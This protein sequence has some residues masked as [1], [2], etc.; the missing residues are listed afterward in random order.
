MVVPKFMQ[1]CKSLKIM[2][3]I[4]LNDRLPTHTM[5]VDLDELI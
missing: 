4:T 2:L 5:E 3:N 1:T